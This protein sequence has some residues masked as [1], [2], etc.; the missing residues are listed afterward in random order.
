[1]QLTPEQVNERLEKRG[2]LASEIPENLDLSTEIKR[3]KKKK[4]AVLLAHY[5]Q[6][7]VIQELADYL[8]D[9]LYLAQV[10]EKV[11][12][13]TI[14]F[15]GV[16]FM[17]ETAKIINPN[18]KVLLPD[19]KAGCSLA[20][21]CPP[22]DF[23]KFIDQYPGAHVVTYI[24]CS[25]EIKALSTI[26]C[27]SSNARRVIESI[28][29]EETIIFAPDK[30]LGNYLIKETGRDMILWNG[31][32]IVHEAFS[33]ERI[34]TLSKSYPNAKFIAHPESESQVLEIA[35]Y[36]GSTSGLLNYVQENSATE[37][38]VAT[39]AGILYEMEKR[40]PKKIFIPAP[41]QD[42]TCACSECAFMKLNTLEKLYLCLKHEK[43]EIKLSNKLI[44]KARL[45]IIKM[46]ELG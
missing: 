28:P 8:G 20:D 34:V 24:N 14:I 27:T 6:D 40:C 11:S 42:E 23:R 2:F 38:I 16:H 44:E 13:E 45:P 21:S 35:D 9:S 5:Y 19:L 15:A 43:P 1:M 41:I 26:V 17:A 37:F 46:L 18:K 29:E 39:E 36:I 10:A 25:A 33:F 32:C 31:S 22:I 12:N 7:G 4:N 30:N 3:L